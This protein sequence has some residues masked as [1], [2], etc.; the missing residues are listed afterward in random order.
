[1]TAAFR[2]LKKMCDSTVLVIPTPEDSF[3][4][5]TDASGS[6]VGG[7]LHVRRGD[8]ELPV[9]F[10]SR[11]LKAAEKNYSV[12]ELKSLAIVSALKHFEYFV[13]TKQTKVVTD[14]K[15]CLALIDGSQK[16]TEICVVTSTILYHPR[17]STREMS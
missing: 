12:T 5:Y 2:K 8:K 17:I 14:H 10:Y 4:L 11:Q 6:G 13:Y 1:M 15:P 3:I 9:G 7:C 16:A